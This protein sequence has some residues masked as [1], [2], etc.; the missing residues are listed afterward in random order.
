[1]ESQNLAIFSGIYAGINVFCQ[2]AAIMLL[3]N[4]YK[5]L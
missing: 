5:L 4:C 2:L 1:M 3:H